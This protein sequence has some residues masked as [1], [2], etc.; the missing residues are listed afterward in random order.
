MLGINIDDM[1]S[2]GAAIKVVARMFGLQFDTLWRRWEREKKKKQIIVVASI[3]TLLLSI[4]VSLVICHKNV[5]FKK[6]HWE[7]LK[8]QTRSVAAKSMSLISENDYYTASILAAEVLPINL[9]APNRP[10]CVEAEKLLNAI[11]Y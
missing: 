1:G 10:F 5:M 11:K 4:L 8:S 9:D 6:T 2:D 3:L 7:L